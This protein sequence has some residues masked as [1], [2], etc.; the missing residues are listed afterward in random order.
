VALIVAATL[1]ACGAEGLAW[2]TTCP[3][4]S[5]VWP[6]CK[7]QGV[8]PASNSGKEV[9][10]VIASQVISL[11]LKNAALVHIA[12]R[13]QVARN[14][15]AQ[16]LRSVGVELVVISGHGVVAVMAN[17]QIKLSPHGGPAYLQR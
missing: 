12:R 17:T 16:P 11:Y 8:A 6:S 7:P 10:L 13:N 1:L 5:S 15:V 3:N 9:A 14:Q 2:T 4:R